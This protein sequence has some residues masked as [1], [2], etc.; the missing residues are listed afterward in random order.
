MSDSKGEFST[1]IGPDACF[2]GELSFEKGAR[3]L[4]TFEGQVVTKGEFVVAEGAKLRG[5]VDA[6]N[7][8]L[9]GEV[10][11]NLKAS[12]KVQ[13]SASAR[14]EGDLQTTRLEVAD[15]AVF[16]GRCVVGANGSNSERPKPASA[17]SQTRN[18]PDLAARAKSGTNEPA[19]AKS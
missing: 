12:E 2:K 15:G 6:A 5:E 10:H 9:D 7:I 17:G 18:A 11:G 4:G 13:L 3:L 16:V 8:R 19:A 1:V 14:L